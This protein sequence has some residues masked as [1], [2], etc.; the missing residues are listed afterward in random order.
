MKFISL[1]LVG[2]LCIA[3]VTSAVEINSRKFISMNTSSSRSKV[4]AT[5]SKAGVEFSVNVPAMA[6]AFKSSYSNITLT[7]FPVSKTET[8]TLYLTPSHSVIDSRSEF[9]VGSRRVGLPDVVAYKGV[10]KGEPNSKVLLNYSNG[11]LIGSIRRESGDRLTVSPYGSSKADD[12]THTVAPGETIEQ[13]TNRPL[14][15]CSTDEENSKVD[16]PPASIR[17]DKS[18]AEILST[19]PL[20]VEIIVEST[21]GFFTGPGRNDEDKAGAYIVAL[22]NMVSLIYEEE[23]NMTYHINKTQIWTTDDPD[24]YEFSGATTGHN[25]SLLIEVVQR[26]RGR[27]I[28]RDLVNVL[29]RPGASRILG[30]ARGIGGICNNTDGSLS[31]YAVC[32]ISNYS[33][34]PT[35]A[36]DDEVATIAHEN[37][38]VF[39]AKHTHNCDW[40]PPLDSC[41]TSTGSMA[42]NFYSGDACNT[43]TPK[44]NTGSIMS[45][46]HLWGKGL[47]MTFLPRVY[48]FLRNEME[49]K[50]CLKEPSASLVKVQ[51]PRGNQVLKAGLDTVIHWT[52]S[53]DIQKVRIEFSSDGGTTWETIPNGDNVDAKLGGRDYGQGIIPWKVP[54]IN[55]TKGLIRVS[56]QVDGA[57][58]GTCLAPFSIASTAL[59]IQSPLGGERFGQLEKPEVQW[60]AGLVNTV[61]V[62]LSTD[63]GG[64]WNSVGTA[65]GTGSYTLELPRIETD[66]AMVRVSDAS[67]SSLV[68][69][70]GKFSIGREQLHIH[71]PNGGD[72]VCAGQPFTITWYTDFI[73]LSTSKVKI[74]YS[75]NNGASWNNVTNIVG[76]DATTGSYT[77]AGTKIASTN[78]LVKIVYK[79]DTTVSTTSF[80]VF[81]IDSKTPCTPMGVDE[82]AQEEH[83]ATMAISPNPIS[84][85][86][87]ATVEFP[88]PCA[89][90]E[91]TLVDTKGAVVAVLGNYDNL[92]SGKHELSFDVSNIV[93]GSYFLTLSCG[94][95]R[96]SA[97]L[98]ILR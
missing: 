33:E 20:E 9:Y 78:A 44:Y 81:T 6:A 7:E 29:S 70:S 45:Y 21:T 10:I 84:S 48:N 58:Y 57:V 2:L 4:P 24:G 63:G 41:T 16:I 61:K 88:A 56:N 85:Q 65:S 64:S 74:F 30:I 71:T 59:T 22:Y 3:T 67:N 89:M 25:D 94:G 15:K 95:Q 23:M 72:I 47:P 73:S 11:D 36:Y 38:H 98:T 46:C 49:G 52:V 19:K 66:Q 31:A 40:K 76:T 13:I 79:A 37:G 35:F 51:L 18:A 86:G 68:S 80:K 69:Q 96:I 12:R 26:W 91:C 97:P 42:D 53:T 75:T 5:L 17:K 54:A 39:G 8:A 32:G 82:Q 28:Q 55:T 77:W 14:F 34:V 83:F 87:I 27:S 92:S 43:G 60:K 50:S 90:I 1:F 93:S 62:E